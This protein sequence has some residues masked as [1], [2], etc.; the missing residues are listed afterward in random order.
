MLMACWQICYEQKKEYIIGE[1]I[2]VP[3]IYSQ[4]IVSFH[5]TTMAIISIK[6]SQVF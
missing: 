1:S 4:G 3:L 2:K 6:F 5:L